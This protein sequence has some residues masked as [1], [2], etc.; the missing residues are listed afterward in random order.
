MANNSGGEKT[1][2]Y[3]KTEKYVEELKVILRD[4]K[5]YVLKSLSSSELEAKKQQ[6]DTE[7]EV[8]RKI[9]DL[10]QKNENILQEAKPKVSKNSSG[11]FLWNVWDKDTGK[12]DLTKLLVGSQGTLGFVTEAKIKLIKPKSDSRLLVI[13]LND[14]KSLADMVKTV[15][16]FRPESFE[17]YDDHT[18]KV[19]MKVLPDLVKKLKGGFF[20]LMW[21][22]LPEFWMSLTG[23]IPKLILIAEF[24]SDNSE[25]AH[26]QAVAAQ[27]G[28]KHFGLKTKVT[29]S[30]EEG[31]KYWV[32]R[33]ESFSL[34]RKNLHG[35]HTAP[36]IDDIVVRPEQLPD[37]LPRLYAI[38]DEY[39]LIYT[40]AGHAGD[41][42]FHIIPLMD[43]HKPESKKIILELSERVYELIFEFKGSISGEHNDGLIRSPFLEK[44]YGAEVYKL[45]V[46]TKNIF[47]PDNIFNPGKKV[48]SNLDY[49]MDHI[50]NF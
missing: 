31:E 28:L 19:A 23:G 15:L 46:E 43:F 50:R 42:N 30:A 48:G 35:L 12:F 21:Q 36:F 14:L 49:T 13:F 9:S 47:D 16:A 29:G 17:S 5:E 24:T 4:G 6:N 40:I 10:V 18:F 11:Y 2:T 33:R 8:Y 3:G 32:I 7:G 26:K 38:L 34:L 41:A 1:L 22:F 27:A 44:M 45:F 25:D 20:K 39:N 37:F